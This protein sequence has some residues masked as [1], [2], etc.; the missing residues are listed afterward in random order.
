MTRVLIA[1]AS[2]YGSVEEVAS[3]VGA[4]L[5]D[6]GVA[7][8]VVPVGDVEDVSATTSSCSG[9]ASTWAGCTVAP[10][11]SCS[12]ITRR[13]SICRSPSS[14][15]GRSATRRPRKEKVRPHLHRGLDRYPALEPAAVA[16]LGGVID[17]AKLSFPF[18]HMPAGDHR[19][20]NEIR[21]FARS[22]ASERVPAA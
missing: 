13:S 14:R 12:G 8:V 20:W 15:W 16:I 6:K 21:D 1:Y 7:C 18:S 19:D 2:K 17:P 5:R 3:Y 22:L 10:G 9:R 4:V 11:G